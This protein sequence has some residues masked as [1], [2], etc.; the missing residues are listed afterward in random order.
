MTEHTSKARDEGEMPDSERRVFHL[1]SGND[2]FP[3]FV[4]FNEIDSYD[5]CLYDYYL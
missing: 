3:F 5:N 2:S 1:L 4:M